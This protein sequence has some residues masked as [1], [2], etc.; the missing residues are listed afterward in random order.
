MN[1]FCYQV[2][3]FRGTIGAKWGRF[4]LRGELQ[5]TSE[6]Y[7]EAL[8]QLWVPKADFEAIWEAPLGASWL[9]NV[10]KLM[11][12]LTISMQMCFSLTRELN[13]ERRVSSRESPEEPFGIPEAPRE[14]PSSF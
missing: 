10:K 14:R 9:Q 5:S 13:F 4:L 8:G 12:I 2:S 1:D 11:R 6:G 7:R 3:T